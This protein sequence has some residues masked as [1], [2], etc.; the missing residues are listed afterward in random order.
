MKIRFKFFNRRIWFN[1]IIAKTT[2]NY[3]W[4]IFTIRLV[5]NYSQKIIRIF[6]QRRLI[7]KVI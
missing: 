1:L 2:R 7:D 3:K 5:R 4:G 6:G